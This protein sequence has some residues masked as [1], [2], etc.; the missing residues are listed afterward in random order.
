MWSWRPFDVLFTLLCATVILLPLLSEQ[1]KAIQL[2]VDDKML[3]ILE[4]LMELF[5]TTEASM[6]IKTPT[7]KEKNQLKRKH[8]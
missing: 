7:K 8:R 6:K 4:K 5:L 3:L 2:A 1:W